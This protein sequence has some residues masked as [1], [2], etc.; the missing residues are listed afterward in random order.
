MTDGMR[1][2]EEL[3]Q[4]IERCDFHEEAGGFCSADGTGFFFVHVF[5]SSHLTR[6]FSRQYL[7]GMVS[8]FNEARKFAEEKKW[9][10][11]IHEGQDDSFEDLRCLHCSA[12]SYFATFM[13]SGVLVRCACSSG[14]TPPRLLYLSGDESW[15]YRGNDCLYALLRPR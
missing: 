10:L 9:T 12:K 8:Q 14:L 1:F 6:L 2:C 7:Q 11:Q 15:L 3:C 5:L 4:E 13:V